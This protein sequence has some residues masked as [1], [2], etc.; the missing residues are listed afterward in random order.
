MVNLLDPQETWAKLCDDYQKTSSQNNRAIEFFFELL[1]DCAE[2]KVEILPLKGLD[3]LIR[4]YPVVA[5]RPMADLDFLIRPENILVV[6][7]L[8]EKKGFQRMPDEGLTYLRG[9]LNLDIIWDIWFLKNTSEIWNN[10][11]IRTFRERPVACLHPE[12]ALTYTIVYVVANRGILTPLFAQDL[13]F[14]LEKEGQEIDWERW[15]KKIRR[16]KLEAPVFHGLSYAKKEGLDQVPDFVLADLKPCWPGQK[17]SL[18]FYEKFT[19]HQGSPKVSYLFTWLGYRGLGGKLKLLKEKFL[20]S[21]FEVELHCGR[22]TKIEYAWRLLTHP[23][24]VLFRA[25]FLLMR[26][27]LLIISRRKKGVEPS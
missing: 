10:K 20:P 6:K 17:F 16:L 26:D 14:F 13:Q 18:F 15:V 27:A 19:S 1:D 11:V 3:F 23:F 7:S 25:L 9:T 5:S 2:A 24:F 8:L 12:D 22:K 21:R 4:A